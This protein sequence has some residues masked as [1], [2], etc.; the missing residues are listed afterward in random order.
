VTCVGTV[1][2]PSLMPSRD[3]PHAGTFRGE[4]SDETALPFKRLLTFADGDALTKARAEDRA[5][6]KANRDSM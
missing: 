1:A 6:W 3:N 2:V 5:K 4:L